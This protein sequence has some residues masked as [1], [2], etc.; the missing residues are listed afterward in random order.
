MSA[1]VP[2][3]SRPP[4]VARSAALCLL[5]AT[6]LFPPAPAGAQEPVGWAG[7]DWVF[8]TFSIVARDPDTGELGVAVTTR[9]ACVGNGVPWARV[10]VGALATQSATRTEYAAEVFDRIAA[11]MT[12]D[13]A[14]A[15]ALAADDRAPSR[16]LGVIAADGT[17]GQHTGDANGGWAGQRSGS[18]FATQGNV[19]VGPEVLDAVAATFEASRGSQRNL[20]DRIIEAMEAGQAAGG[21]RRRGRMQ[22]AAVVVVDPREGMARRPDGQTVHINVCENPEPVAEMRR[23][24]DT[25][26]QTLGFRTL[27]RF[28]GSDV[29]QVKLMLH[30]LGYYRADSTP[31]VR[32][33]GWAAYDEEIAAAVDAFRG[34]QGLSTPADGSPSGLV[35]D[36][37]VAALWEALEASGRAE[38]VRAEIRALTLVRR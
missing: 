29:W 2:L 8:H 10:G 27:Q 6:G 26:S 3:R 35:D 15:D 24:Y 22:S 21:D 5:A 30:A 14:L 32:D 11:G 36:V 20:A 28:E 38:A 1:P 16:Q 4:A 13:S 25:V 7:D 12:A 34:H 23:I 17:I 9:N 33:R 18:D 37:A 19:L 31:L